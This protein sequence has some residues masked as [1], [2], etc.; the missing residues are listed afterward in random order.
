MESNGMVTIANNLYQSG[1][2]LSC[3]KLKI[4]LLSSMHMTMSFN[5]IPNGK[6]IIKRSYLYVINVQYHIYRPIHLTIFYII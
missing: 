6:G 1:N 2:K 4:I 5:V 3:T